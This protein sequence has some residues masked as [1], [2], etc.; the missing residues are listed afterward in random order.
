MPELPE[1]ETIRQGLLGALVGKKIHQLKVYEGRLRWPIPSHLSEELKHSC[2][3]S[4]L[5]RAK[6]LIITFDHGAVLIHLGMSGSL[7]ICS[8]D[9]LRRQH[10]HVDFLLSSGK[11]LRYC[12]PRRFGSILWAPNPIEQ[13]PRL[14]HLGPEPLSRAFNS[15]YMK[16]YC[17][18]RRLCIKSWLMNQSHVVGVGN[19]YANEALYGAQIHPLRLAGELSGDEYKKLCSY[20]KKVLNQAIAQGGTTLKDFSHADGEPGYFQQ[21]LKIYGRSGLDCDRCGGVIEKI[22]INQRSSYFCPVCQINP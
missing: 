21:S 4:V 7:R 15:A 18:G 5:R 19:I 2:V 20:V 1:V 13:H 22:M 17:F 9:D 12:D 14:I 16:K 3:R 8:P 11:A 10:D 6:Y